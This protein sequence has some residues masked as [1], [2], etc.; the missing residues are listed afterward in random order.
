MI[1][2][3]NSKSNITSDEEL[4][5]QLSSIIE[6]DLKRFS[7]NITR[8]E[9]HLGDEDGSKE[10]MNDKRCTMEVRP[11]GMQPIVATQH[12]NSLFEAVSGAATK[13]KNSL[14]TIYG[15]M[16]NY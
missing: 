8:V 16:R 10:G 11:E 6:K 15:K 7:D 2:Q 9:V 5:G 1:I 3:F 13:L 12:A 4:R 14:D